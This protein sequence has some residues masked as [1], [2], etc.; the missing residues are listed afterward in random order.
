MKRGT[1][2]KMFNVLDGK[3]H[4][5]RLKGEDEVKDG[6]RRDKTGADKSKR[7]SD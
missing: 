5:A 1:E 4:W 3:E 7:V 6:I 2:P